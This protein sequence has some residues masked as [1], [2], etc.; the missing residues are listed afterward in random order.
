[1]NK[2]LFLISNRMLLL[3][4]FGHGSYPRNKYRYR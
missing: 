2:K 1:M 4:V 3:L